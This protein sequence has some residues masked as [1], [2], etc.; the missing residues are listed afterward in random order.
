MEA[1]VK[2]TDQ[3]SLEK[4]IAFAKQC[5]A[6]RQTATSE[7]L[8]AHCWAVASQAEK[9]AI[10]FYQDLREEYVP[11]NLEETL[12]V[13]THCGLLH[14]VLNVSACAFENI[15]EITNVQVAAMVAAISR[16]YRLVETK[17][18][19]EFRGRLS[20]S[21]VSTQIVAV[22][23]IIC[24]AKAISAAVDAQGLAVATKAKKLLGQLDGDL[25]AIHAANKYYVLRLYVHAARNLL[26]TV[27]KNIKAC[28]QRAKIEKLVLQ[29]T[30][31]LRES[32]AAAAKGTARKKP[33]RKKKEV[34]YA[35]KRTPKTN[36]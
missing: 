35:R 6:T 32:D 24:S 22:A 27:S 16:D 21:A 33:V 11:E 36:P 29:N 18:D 7:D 31:T 10:K 2:K 3:L 23:D 28:R 5:Y 13:I 15:A 26:V 25:M 9:M 8:Y 20:Q 34:R 4:T 12:A 19:M 1:L 30:Q 17:R 14:D